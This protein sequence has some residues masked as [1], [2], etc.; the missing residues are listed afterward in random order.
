MASGETLS[1]TALVNEAY[2]KLRRQLPGW[3]GAR[4][5]SRWWRAPCARS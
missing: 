1:T 4:I 3:K 5:S 2:L